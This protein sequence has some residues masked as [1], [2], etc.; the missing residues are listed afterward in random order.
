MPIALQRINIERWD[1]RT[2]RIVEVARFRS[3]HKPR[4]NF[5][6]IMQYIKN[7]VFIV[8]IVMLA[9]C[10]PGCGLLLDV[11]TEALPFVTYEVTLKDESLRVIGITGRLFNYNG[12]KVTLKP[13]QHPERGGLL[14]I[15]LGAATLGG[16]ALEIERRDGNYIVD[17]KGEDFAFTYDL[18]LTVEDRYS[19][20]IRTMLTFLDRDRCRIMGRDV[21]LLPAVP[22]SDGIIIDMDLFD[23]G[24]FQSPWGGYGGRM[25][26]PELEELPLTL[27]VNG[28][29]RLIEDWIG[30]IDVCLAIA[31]DWEFKDEEFFN[32]IR[33]I[34]S[35]EMALFGTAPH[36][37]YLF[38]CD[39]NPVKGGSKFRYYGV[40]FTAG[41]LLLLDPHIDR[42]ELFGE[43]MALIAHELF[44]SWNGEAVRSDGE[45]FLWFIEGVTVYYSYR[46]LR[47]AD[48]INRA[49]YEA[50]MEMIRRRYLDNPYLDSVSIGASGNSDLGDKGMVNLLYDGGCLA[51]EALEQRL[52]ELSGGNVDLIDVIKLL[53][54]EGHP[55]DE[56]ALIRAVESLC[57]RDISDFITTLIHTPAPEILVESPAD[58]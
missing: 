24:S 37:R 31:G 26:V 52:A 29:Y 34:V 4:N 40:H 33:G 54:A 51:A 6:N 11:R 22:I 12:G 57:S 49:Q 50:R 13:M 17:S 41:M 5:R 43:T 8:L 39:R 44:H 10:I 32:V 35:R 27:A 46:I 53:A 16:R 36:D 42:S 30:G 9:V 2:F 18:V 15:D 45:D 7:N 55:A 3:L 38:V 23:E 56:E 58:S 1:R 28:E 47:D 48:I 14:P 21:F 25:I 19:P 20:D